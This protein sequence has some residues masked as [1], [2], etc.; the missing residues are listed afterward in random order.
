MVP[1]VIGLLLSY[2]TNGN[3]AG[4]TPYPEVN[5]G[6]S[7][8]PFISYLKAGNRMQQPESCPASFYELML[9]CWQ[10]EPG[11][12]PAPH[13]LVAQLTPDD[14]IFD[15]ADSEMNTGPQ[16]GSNKSDSTGSEAGHQSSQE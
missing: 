2:N 9:Q 12:R 8:E 3:C 1:S 16:V 5:L 13:D 10:L 11:L 6:A 7:Y 14:S 4:H 15:D